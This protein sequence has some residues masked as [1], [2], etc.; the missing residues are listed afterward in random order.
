MHIG[1]FCSAH[2]LGPEYTKPVE[3]LARH[4]GEHGHTLVWGGSN[5]G[6]MQTVASGVRQAGGKLIGITM[7]YYKADVFADA[8]EMVIAKDLFDR[9]RLLI[10]R[11][12]GVVILVGGIG[13]L[14]EATDILE[15]KR[16]GVDV[17]IIFL[18]TN[19]FFDSLRQ[20]LKVM[21]DGGFLDRPIDELIDFAATP[22]EAL[23]ILVKKAKLDG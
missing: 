17:P 12:D 21:E 9:K 10:E 7:E 16:E 1:V 13:T 2:A 6:L 18:N 4:V 23:D 3:D 20:Q 15:V 22:H 11:S 5:T 14:D 19:G 8:E